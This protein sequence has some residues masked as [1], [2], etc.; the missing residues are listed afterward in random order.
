MNGKF[1]IS[2]DFELHWGLFD[3]KTVSQYQENLENT[4]KALKSI[5]DLSNQYNIRLTV[6]TV[7]FLFAKNKKELTFYTPNLKPS[8]SNGILNAYSLFEQIGFDEKDDPYHYA[9]SLL[10]QLKKDKRHEIG[11][12]TFCHYYCNEPDQTINEFEA[13]L[14]SAVNIAKSKGVVLKSIVFPRN[15]VN[16]NYLNIL[17]SYGITSY[18][19]T[20]NSTIYKS[21]SYLPVIMGRGLRLMDSYIN[22]FGYF[23]YPLKDLKSFQDNCVNLPSSR[24]LR[25]YNISL[26]FLESLKIMRIKKAMTH[27]AKN[28]H[29]YHLWWHP[30][31][32]G[33]NF[34]ENM[35]NLEMIYNHF[36]FLKSKYNFKSE[37]ME[38]LSSEIFNNSN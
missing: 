13:D 31:N 24:F 25:P 32:F 34:R 27:A 22:L 23:T 7:G 36:D 38:S 35:R 14:K 16:Q 5:V 17:Y 10:E 26:K 2:L 19:G 20:E 30:H 3:L 18:R 28:G 1:V 21:N 29:L 12:H 9:N 37:T 11:T 8:Y 15:Q 4:P 33:V 6:A